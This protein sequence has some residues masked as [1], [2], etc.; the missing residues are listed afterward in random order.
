MRERINWID[1]AKGITILIVILGH[2][3]GENMFGSTMRGMIY[4]FHMPLFFILSC[5]TYSY[6]KTNSEWKLKVKHA[7]VHLISPAVIIYILTII[8][9]LMLHPVLF[10]SAGYWKGKIYAYIFSSG[11]E[12]TFNGFHVDAAGIP[13]FFFALFIGRALFD[14]IQIQF[15]DSQ[16]KAISWMIGGM[17]IFFGATQW[18]PFSLDIALAIFPFFY[19]GFW[20]K[21]TNIFSKTRICKLIF[22][23]CIWGGDIIY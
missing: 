14:Y 18:L 4:S 8:W 9:D 3:I 13:W 11:V 21:N 17:G 22:W 16:L 23:T 20:L 10:N 2:T 19:Y 7:F 12:T 1:F 6:S 5:I 15:D